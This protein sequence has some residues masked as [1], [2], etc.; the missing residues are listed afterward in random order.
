MAYA[1]IQFIADRD[2]SDRLELDK[3]VKELDKR[4]VLMYDIT[5][6]RYRPINI[7]RESCEGIEPD[8]KYCTSNYGTRNTFYNL[9]NISNL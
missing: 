8:N 5:S 7:E 2:I 6:T 4:T 3:T 9:Y 1:I